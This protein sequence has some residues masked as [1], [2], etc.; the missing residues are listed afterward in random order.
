MKELNTSKVALTFGLIGGGWHLLWSFLILIGLAQ[1]LINFVFWMHML[2]IPYKVTGFTL[3]QA[4]ILI[5]ITFI[6]GYA[7]GWIF[8]WL[9]NK[10]HKE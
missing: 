6:A 1:S 5:V 8:A 10:I 7:G 4:A 3:T 9:W 2:T